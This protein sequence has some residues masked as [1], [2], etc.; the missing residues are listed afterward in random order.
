MVVDNADVVFNRELAKIHVAILCDSK[1]ILSL[2]LR[3][4]VKWVHVG[5]SLSASVAVQVGHWRCDSLCRL[6]VSCVAYK[7]QRD[8]IIVSWFEV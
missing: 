8:Q 7:I 3:H 5:K 6:Q 4:L 1:I 2:S